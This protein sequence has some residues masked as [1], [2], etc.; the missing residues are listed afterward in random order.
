MTQ[1]EK[2]NHSSLAVLLAILA[3]GLLA[4]TAGDIG[5]TWDEPAYIAAAESYS[6]WFGDLFTRPGYALQP[7]I[8]YRQWAANHEHPPLDKV[9]SGA[10]WSLSRGLFDDLTAHR[11]GNILLVGLLVGLLYF[12]M[13]DAYGR[14]A[15]LFAVA[16]LLSM[17]RFFFHAHLSALDVPAAVSVFAV[18]FVFWRTLE[19]RQWWWGLLLGLAW[20][21]ALAVKINAVFVPVAMGLWLLAFHRRWKAILRLILMGLTAI[22][23]FIATWP[24]LYSAT[25]TRLWDYILFVTVNHWPIGQWY[26][27]RWYMPPP[28]HFAFVMLW[29]VVP[30]TVF[31]LA[32]GGAIRSGRGRHDGGLGWLLVLS[33]LIPLL[34]LAIGQSMIYDNDRLLM[35]AFPFVAALSGVGFAGLLAGLRRLFARWN[36]PGL[37]A[38]VGV[39][40]GLLLLLPQTLTMVGMYPHLLSYYSEGVGGLPGAAAMNLETTYWCESYEAAFEYINEHAA[41]YDRVWA[42]PWSHDVLIYYQEHGRLREDLVILIPQPDIVSVFGSGA[43]RILPGTYRE[44]GWLIFQYRQ[45]QYGVFR[46]NYEVLT[47]LQTLEPVQRVEYQ[48][49]PIME[50][51]QP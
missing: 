41:P 4:V 22:P 44:A 15:G 26:F 49:V 20:G 47:Y 3:V 1:A 7:E 2:H 45:T 25:L 51:Y 33:A 6:E 12:W 50:L 27:G 48:G 38:P 21:L 18:T 19:R 43:G 34:A 32:V 46:E 10:A 28:W 30:L 5:L 17:P 11:L 29:A 14:P 8:I 37:L 40:L 39:A 36:R 23:V 24:W 35:A 9:W 31:L 16:A 42:E 13:A